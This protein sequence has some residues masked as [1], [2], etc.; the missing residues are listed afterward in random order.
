MQLNNK[1]II[2]GSGVGGLATAIR[3]QLQGYAVTVY[4]K[5]SYAGGKLS[6]FEKQGYHFDAG[7]SLFT[8]PQ[9]IVELFELANEPIQKVKVRNGVLCCPECG[10]AYDPNVFLPFMKL[11][12]A[13]VL[14]LGT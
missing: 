7:P 10:I 2:I 3:L 14:I 6:A 8:Q 12:M 9:N 11:K 4:E 13:I 5:N 1:A